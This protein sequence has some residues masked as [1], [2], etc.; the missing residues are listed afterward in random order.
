MA[1]NFLKINQGIT[2]NGQSNAPSSPSNGD[3]YYNSTFNKFQK[4]E[5]GQ[6]IDLGTNSHQ[7]V[8]I[9]ATSGG[10]TNLAITDRQIQYF[11]GT[12]AQTV[13]LPNATLYN[14]VGSRFEIYNQSTG[15]ITVNTFGG[16]FLKVVIP[17]QSVTVKLVDQGTAAGT[18]AIVNSGG[19][20][21]GSGSPLDPDQESNF[22]YYARSD[23]AVDTNTF[24]QTVNGA[25]FTGAV[26]EVLA[27]SRVKFTTSGQI[28]QSSNLVGTEAKSDAAII[29][30]AYAK[31]LYE[32]SYVDTAPV[33]AFSRDGG[34]S[35]ANATMLRNASTGLMW[36][37]DYS[38]PEPSTTL[39]GSA[40]SGV[41]TS[42]KR[43]IAAII[44]PA[45]NQTITYFDFFVGTTASSGFITGSIE[46]VTAGAP[47]GTVIKT[48][49]ESKLAGTDITST[50]AYSRFTLQ[51]PVTLTAGT[52][53]AI[54]VAADA[55]AGSTLSTES[56]TS[57]TSWN[58]SGATHNGTSWA[59]DANRYAFDV[60]IYGQDLRIK[61][62]SGDASERRLK[63][64]GVDFVL[65]NTFLQY[66]K[67]YFEERNMTSTEASTG[68]VT[69]YQVNATPGTRQIKV[70]YNGHIYTEGD[71]ALLAPNVIQFP[72]GFFNSGDLLRFEV[73]Y[74]L[75]DSTSQ[76]LGKWGAYYDA[77]VGSAAQVAAGIATHTSLV[78]ALASYPNGS[79]MILDEYVTSETITISGRAKI[80]GHGYDSNIA[81]NVTV[82]GSFATI[83]NV[84]FGGNLTITGS[85][86]FI[87][88]CFA[89]TTSTI[90]DSGSNV[91]S[92]IV[93]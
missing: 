80:D 43:R 78:T 25:V 17:N 74:G 61:V 22:L 79:I 66:G 11:T 15:V 31:L 10:T 37:A 63:G 76:S 3:I 33:V 29:N 58:V 92:I 23:F 89:A 87:T 84:K 45:Y 75:I 59:T 55:T 48:C 44:T 9:T 20:G 85:G 30:R 54:I 7:L 62:T 39:S 49:S 90:T 73:T 14:S 67:N 1:Q 32:D 86:N 12:S 82:S 81:G 60:L 36:T 47:N 24:A 68:T 16:A 52:S 83:A 5:N 69:L 56:M 57:P 91:K 38:F 28:F 18:W 40:P 64:F 6:W 72:V 13:V 26:D 34:A 77:I 35:F 41:S 27:L 19:S 46:A 93:G 51:S 4:Y 42:A 65:G 21:A 71:F 2:F 70:H 53:Y 8:Q 50:R 88:P